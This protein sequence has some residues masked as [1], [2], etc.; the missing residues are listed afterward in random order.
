MK[1]RKD[2]V[3]NSSSSSFIIGR[4]EDESVTVDFVFKIV[5]GIYEEYLKKRDV[6]IEYISH[7]K[8]LGIVYDKSNPYHEQFKYIKSNDWDKEREVFKNIN[9]DF[10]LDQYCYFDKDYNWLKFNSYKK[11]EKYWITRIN[12]EK[13]GCHAP[14]TLYDFYRKKS[15][16]LLHCYYG[17]IKTI[18]PNLGIKSDVLRWYFPYVEQAF[19]K[20]ECCSCKSRNWCDQEECSENKNFVSGKDI[21]EDKAC[22][23]ILGRV[24]IDSESGYIPS[25]VVERLLEISEYGCNHMG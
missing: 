9:R 15:V 2:F 22:L 24:C 1:I 20:Q 8:E 5:K 7:N 3:T 17:G 4:M 23:Y 14:F 25:Y 19:S 13:G 10:G 18:R 6:L 12:N 21:P 16:K 11:Y